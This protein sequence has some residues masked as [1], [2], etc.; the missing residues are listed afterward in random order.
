MTSI[1]YRRPAHYGVRCLATAQLLLN[2]SWPRPH[3]CCAAGRACVHLLP[4]PRGMVNLGPHGLGSRAV[5]PLGSNGVY[6]LSGARTI[7]PSQSHPELAFRRSSRRGARS[8]SQQGHRR[9]ADDGTEGDDGMTAAERT[10]ARAY[11][12]GGGPVHPMFRDGED[13]WELQDAVMQSHPPQPKDPPQYWAVNERTTARGTALQNR[14]CFAGTASLRAAGYL[15]R[16]GGDKHA[17]HG[18]FV[19]EDRPLLARR[20]DGRLRT[21]SIAAIPQTA[22][23]VGRWGA[24]QKYHGRQSRFSWL[25]VEHAPPSQQPR[26]AGGRGPSSFRKTVSQEML[27]HGLDEPSQM[28]E[29]RQKQ[30]YSHHG[31]APCASF[32]RRAS[33]VTRYASR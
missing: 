19:P 25:G 2:C 11:G 22:G 20:R 29:A 21:S 5:A 24:H 14:R 3:C 4:P 6:A 13:W 32:R 10:R 28:A 9:R 31:G 18:K 33:D 12:G 17:R 15:Q 8:Q 26:M 23:A 7:G 16:Q 30:L 27:E 1:V